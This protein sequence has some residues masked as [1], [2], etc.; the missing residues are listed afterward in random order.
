MVLLSIQRTFIHNAITICNYDP[1]TVIEGAYMA[2]L[3]VELVVGA[4]MGAGISEAMITSTLFELGVH[5]DQVAAAIDVSKTALLVDQILPAPFV[6][7]SGLGQSSASF[8]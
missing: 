4:A 5:P 2:G 7:G 6:I 8:P 1:A 3:S